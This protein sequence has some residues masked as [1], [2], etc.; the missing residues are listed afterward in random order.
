MNNHQRM[1][2]EQALL[3]SIPTKQIHLNFPHFTVGQIKHLVKR[4]ETNGFAPCFSW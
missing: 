1:T 4:R 3:D 2:A